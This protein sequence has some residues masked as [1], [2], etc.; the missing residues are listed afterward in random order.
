MKKMFK[1]AISVFLVVA[2]FLCAAPLGGFV[3][4]DLPNILEFEAEAGDYHIDSSGSYRLEVSDTQKCATILEFN[5][6]INGDV[7]I[8]SIIDGYLILSIFNGAFENCDNLTGVTIPN[9]VISIGD[10]AF[11]GCTSLTSVIIGEKVT[12]IGTYAFNNCTSLTSVTMGSSVTSISSFVFYN[13]SSL[14]NITF[15]DTSTW[16]RTTNS[17]NWNDKTGGTKTTLTNASSNATYFKST[18]CNY[19]WYKI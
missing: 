9:S 2:M 16:Y 3:G 15:E 4:L 1:K 6:S 10:N 19:Y 8:P 13:C 12:S 11:D 5:S 7:V 14:K 17:S 18:Y